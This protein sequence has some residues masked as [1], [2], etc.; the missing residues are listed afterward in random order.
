MPVPANNGFPSPSLDLG[1]G[2]VPNELDVDEPIK[3][4]QGKRIRDRDEYLKSMLSDGASAPEEL[5]VKGISI[6][7]TPLTGAVLAPFTYWGF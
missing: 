5:D 1:Q 2:S 4:A 6:D 3:S 7:G